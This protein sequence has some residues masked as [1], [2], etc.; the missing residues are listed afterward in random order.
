MR[1]VSSWLLDAPDRVRSATLC[2]TGAKIGQAEGWH[3]R[4]QAVRAGGTAVL[5]DSSPGRWFGP[6]FPER[7][8]DRAAALLED[9]AGC[10]AESYAAACDALADFDVRPRLAEVTTPVLALAGE[11]DASIPLATMRHLAAGTPAGRLEILDGVAHQAPAEAPDRVAELITRHIA[12]AVAHPA[13]TLGQVRA[14]GMRVRREVLGDAHVDRALA[15]TT[16][17]TQDFQDLITS[18]A[19]GSVWTRPGLDRRS[20]SLITLTAL[21]ARGHHE[22]LAMHIRAARRNG[23]SDAEIA[24]VFL[25]TAIYCGVPDANTAF[26]IASQTLAELNDERPGDRTRGGLMADH[27]AFVYAAVRTPFG[28]YAGGLSEIRPDDLAATTLQ[29]LLAKVPGLATERIDEVVLGNANG[30]GEDNRNVGRMAALL[31]GLPVSVP[32]TTVNR[33]CGSSLDAAMIGSRMIETGDAQVVVAGGVESMSRSPWVLPKPGRAYPAG[34]ETLVSTTLGWRL[35]NPAM[36][37]EWTVSLGEANEQLQEKF[38]VSRERQDDFAARSHQL[39]DQAW[40][41]GF[42]D[43]FAV[44][45]PGAE[46][47]RDE[48]IRPGSTPETLAALKPAFRPTGTITAGNASPLN[49]GASAVLLGS[50]QR[51]RDPRG[52]AAGPDRRSGQLRAGAAGLR[53]RAGRG[54]QPSAG[55]GRHR[56]GRRRRGRAQRGLRRPVS[57]LPGRLEGR[58]RHRQHP[59]RGD[60]HRTPAGRVGHSHP[61]HAHRGVAGASSALGG[62]RHLHRRRSGPGRGGREH[63]GGLSAM[64][65]IAPDPD[66]AVRGIT[67]GS[68]VLIGGFGRAGLPFALIDAVRRGGA[69]D[70]TVVNNNAGNGTTGLAALLAAGA[71]RKII[72]SFPR[73]TDSFVFD[74]LYRSGAIEL[75]VVPQ[76]NL[77]ER[78]RA[79]GAGIGGFYT[80]TGV[81]TL[82]AEGKEVREIDGR[83]YVLEYP[84]KADAALI[85][86]HRA[87]RLGNLVYRKTG[88]NFGPIMATAAALTIAEVSEVVPVGAIDPEV[89]VTPGI[90]VDRVVVAD[91]APPEVSA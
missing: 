55:R 64:I 16:A 91:P 71:V 51:G 77:A 73:Q 6:G 27:S 39:A 74:E 29:G 4:A 7:D 60:R 57:G 59:R 35:V 20:R 15:G 82:L 38:G 90:F 44:P 63:R 89:V 43:Q 10:D 18:Y 52:R 49:D 23:L 66:T 42:Y 50:E 86:A 81:G 62:G 41:D 58:P 67:D 8:P 21:V 1:S 33:L 9:L 3:E 32:A 88:R 54:R 69:R 36:P 79:G 40:S 12:G 72:C 47:A 65:E 45:V 22:E 76:G 83:A 24:E 26:R 84:I 56:L 53:V 37:P 11:H 48:S 14:E 2:C 31:A 80:P 85:R 28:R 70:L 25:Q 61:R 5:L 13:R 19:W 46:L 78:I 34:N 17:L 68:T 87:D 75:E 30:A